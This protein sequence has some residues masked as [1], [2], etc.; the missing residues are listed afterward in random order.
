MATKKPKSGGKIKPAV[1][2]GDVPEWANATAVG[3]L[4]GKSVRRIQQLTQDGVLTTEVPPGGGTRKYK[5]CDTVQQYIDHV[6]QKAHESAEGGNKAELGIKKLEAEIALKQSQGELH[7]LKTDIAKGKYISSLQA[8]EELADFMTVFRKFAEAIPSR[9]AG[10]M[11]SFTD[12]ATARTMEKSMRKE[13]EAM[14]STFV[15][16]AEVEEAENE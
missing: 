10:V 16:A 4:L 11:S 13:L 8:E 15:D 6:E 2:S 12:V 3:K 9:M 1:L 7:M 14:L 5:T